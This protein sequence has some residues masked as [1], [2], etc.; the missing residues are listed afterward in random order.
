MAIA[1]SHWCLN[2]MLANNPLCNRMFKTLQLYN[3][4]IINSPKTWPLIENL[5]TV[6]KSTRQN[7]PENSFKSQSPRNSFKIVELCY[8]TRDLK[9]QACLRNRDSAVK[10][11]PAGLNHNSGWPNRRIQITF[12]SEGGA[13]WLITN[14]F[15]EQGIFRVGRSYVRWCKDKLYCRRR[16]SSVSV[17][18]QLHCLQEFILLFKR[19]V[20]TAKYT[21]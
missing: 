13:L 17:E 20:T 14:F 19:A 9:C 21:A 4:K 16:W 11:T 8:Q 3:L 1:R 6:L 12:F 5:T 2:N 15:V 7:Y 18:P 10:M